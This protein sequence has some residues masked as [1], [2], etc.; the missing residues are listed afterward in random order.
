MAIKPNVVSHRLILALIIIFFAVTAV[1]YSCSQPGKSDIGSSAALP[2]NHAFVGDQTCQSCHE[3]EVA[4]WQGSHHDYAMKEA[5]PASVLGD[6]G[7]V[8]FTHRGDTYRFFQR[9]SLYMVEAPGPDGEQALY[10]ITHTFGWEPLQQYLVDFGKGKLQALNIAWDTERKQWFAL[11]PEEDIAHGDW[12]HWTGGAM[13]WNTMCADCHSTNLQQNYIAEADSF[14]TTWASIN[15]SCEA[16][17]GPGRKHVEFVQSEEASQAT[18]ER[19]RQDLRLTG[20]TS[21]IRQINQCAQCH[22]LRE[23]LTGTYDH[24]GEFSD[25]FGLMLPHPESYFADGQIKEEVYVYGSF[26]QSKM[27][28]NGVKCSDCHDPHSLELKANVTDNSLCMQCHEPRYNTFDHH[29]HQINTEASQCVNCHMPGR[30]YME[31]DFRRDHSFRVPRPDLSAQFGTPNA[32]NSCHENQ[33]AEWASEAIEQ[34]YGPNRSEHFSEVLVRAD[35]LG[36]GALPGLKQLIA[37]TSM[38]EIAR[39]VA[40]WQLGQLSAPESIDILE[41]VIGYESVLMRRTAAR[42]LAGLPE[43]VKKPVLEEAL[44]D[45]VRAVRLAAAE[46]LSEFNAGDIAF[47]RKQDFKN[48]LKEYRQYLDANQYFPQG[49]MNLGQFYERQGKLEEAIEAYRKA[50]QKD[51]L[52]AP[53]R[54]NLAYLYNRQGDNSKAKEQLRIVLKQEPRYGPAYYSLA[55]LLAE[56]GRLD[57]AAPNFQ[58]AAELMPEN[59][60]VHYNL[61]IAY[62]T[63]ANPVQAEQAYQRAIELDPESPDYRYGICTLYLQQQEYNKARVH[64]EKLAGLNPGNPQVQSLLELIRNNTRGSN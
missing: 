14:H 58:K 37:D 26:L 38:P 8:T 21:Q 57:E 32:C 61:A 48:A 64:A 51:S 52:F 20:G 46:G 41:E 47:H 40:V 31:V 23:E 11:N 28:Q 36:S 35:S 45:T 7:D 55:L 4:A 62:Q 33:S 12:L 63:M 16:C 34:W 9:D 17:H 18:I 15:V 30:Y 42:I 60:R 49:Q 1:M 5:G 53:A 2:V 3:G 43:Q 29:K 19:I 25:H 56:Q 39:A 13:N 22:A 54:I 59:A 10:R 6:F 24:T 44:A 27:F 50:I